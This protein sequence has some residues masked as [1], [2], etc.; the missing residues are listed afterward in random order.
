[1]R[2]SENKSN[3][4]Y[5]VPETAGGLKGFRRNG[6]RGKKGKEKIVFGIERYIDNML[7]TIYCDDTGW[8]EWFKC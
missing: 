1:M 4:Y 3:Y 7:P 5:N 8:D 2:L 6:Q